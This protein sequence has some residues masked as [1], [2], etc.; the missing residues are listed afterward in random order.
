MEGAGGGDTDPGHRVEA[1]STVV[2]GWGQVPTERRTR[3]LLGE[4]L[5][6]QP[7]EE[8]EAEAPSEVN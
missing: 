7:K 1:D 6:P 2:R 3:C 4:G 5:L 8:T